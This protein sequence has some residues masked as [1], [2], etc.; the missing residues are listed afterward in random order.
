MD[1]KSGAQLRL[2]PCRLWRHDVT[3][4]R[5]INKLFHR[6]RIEGECNLHFTA[7]DA[8][9]KFSKSTDTTYEVDSLGCS[10]I[11][12]VKDSVQNKV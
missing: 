12:D 3:G 4:I 8:T 10:E 2:E 1:R 11:L 7:V 5:Y 6:N 9:G